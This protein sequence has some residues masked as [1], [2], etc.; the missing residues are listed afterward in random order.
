MT[1]LSIIDEFVLLGL[2]SDPD[3]Q[4]MLFVLFL[5]IYLLTLIGNLMMIDL[6]GNS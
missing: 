3:I 2:S 6:Y 1:N 5:G 4:T